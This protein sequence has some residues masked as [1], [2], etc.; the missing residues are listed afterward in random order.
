MLI[1]SL[2]SFEIREYLTD[3]FAL[4]DSTI[5]NAVQR[6]VKSKGGRPKRLPAQ[7]PVGYIALA[8]AVATASLTLIIFEFDACRAAEAYE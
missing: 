8:V 6:S 3:P 4:S 7:Q 5:C 2:E 1:L